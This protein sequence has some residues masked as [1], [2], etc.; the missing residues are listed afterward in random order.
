MLTF[1]PLS[2]GDGPWIRELTYA[3]GT[4]SADFNFGSMFLWDK[5]YR[6]EV[7]RRGERVAA[8]ACS[9]AHPIFPFPV[10]T[11]ELESVVEEMREYATIKGFPFEIR[12][13]EE[14]HIELLEAL[15]PGRF[16]ITE[17]RD[18]S[19]YIYLAESLASLSGKKLHAKRNFINRFVQS[20]GDWSF[21]KLSHEDF[22]ACL[23]LLERWDESEDT[24]GGSVSGERDAVLRALSHYDLLG[25]LGGAL[26]VSGELI[27][28]TIG[29]PLS[30]ECFDVHFEKAD[31]S[32]DGAYPMINREFVRLVLSEYPDTKYINREDDMGL[33]NLRQSKLSYHPDH[34][35][36]KHTAHWRED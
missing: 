11:G 21:K 26:Y 7:C 31:A 6:Q 12:G 28:F 5:R 32:V 1:H 33:D 2:I 30:R 24:S 8:I 22:P 34:L 4:Q 10:G 35:L 18:S 23:R 9:G 3:S 19:D 25:L 27:A 16:T 17:D 29:E 15:F 36:M 20:H 13:V 14:E